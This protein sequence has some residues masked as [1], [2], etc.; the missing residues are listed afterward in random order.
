MGD[1]TS[2]L[3]VIKITRS[4]QKL[5]KWSYSAREALK[6][7]KRLEDAVQ[8]SIKRALQHEVDGCGNEAEYLWR[9]IGRYAVSDRPRN[10]KNA[11]MEAQF[12]GQSFNNRMLGL[13]NL[14]DL[15]EKLGNF[16]QA[17][18]EQEILIARAPS[19]TSD[20]NS[21]GILEFWI[22]NLTR[23]YGKFLERVG[24]LEIPGLDIETVKDLGSLSLLLRVTALECKDLYVAQLT[25]NASVFL[26]PG[27]GLTLLHLSAS[28]GS[29]TFTT[30]LLGVGDEIDLLDNSGRTALHLAAREGHFDVVRTLLES[31]ADANWQDDDD[32]SP[33]HFAC[34]YGHT[35]VVGRVKELD[36]AKHSDSEGSSASNQAIIPRVKAVSKPTV[37]SLEST[38]PILIDV[39]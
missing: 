13:S 28:R 30:L 9:Q 15:H 26:S 24:A 36:Q 25:A 1:L 14:V 27:A 32:Y 33:L 23:L 38:L 7:R 16:P 12:H 18:H 21:Q 34:V 10:I 31:R 35:D 19:L 37:G 22:K 11:R 20:N 5:H 3:D 4:M 6:I 39:S 8:E 2:L 29:L 17:E